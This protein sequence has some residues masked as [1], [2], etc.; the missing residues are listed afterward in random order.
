MITECLW[1]EKRWLVNI[2][3]EYL[4]YRKKAEK[5]LSELY[6]V[7]VKVD[8]LLPLHLHGRTPKGTIALGVACPHSDYRQSGYCHQWYPIVLLYMSES[9]IH[10]F[11]TKG[12]LM[13]AD[14]SPFKVLKASIV[15][16]RLFFACFQQEDFSL[17]SLDKSGKVCICEVC[18]ICGRGCQKYHRDS[19]Q[20][21]DFSLKLSIAL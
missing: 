5:F 6:F 19:R 20:P 15:R 13:T 7:I 12:P 10:R 9:L 16:F 1:M 4:E 14:A 8:D 3:T 17:P 18:A 21:P 2:V 11:P